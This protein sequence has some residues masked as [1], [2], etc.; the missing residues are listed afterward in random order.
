MKELTVTWSPLALQTYLKTLSQILDRWTIK[1]AEDF[2]NKVLSLI[3]KLRTKKHLCPPSNK[4][5]SLRRCVVAPQ[6]SLIYQIQD[7]IIEIVAF[8]DNR[9]QHEY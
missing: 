2:E 5:K 8:I 7:S 1:E 3:A 4:H 6:T 9:S